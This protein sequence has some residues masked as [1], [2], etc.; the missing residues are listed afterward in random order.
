MID[1]SLYEYMDTMLKQAPASMKCYIY[2]DIAWNARM[3]SY[4]SAKTMFPIILYISKWR[5]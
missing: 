5:K 2:D 4:P 3:V 1:N